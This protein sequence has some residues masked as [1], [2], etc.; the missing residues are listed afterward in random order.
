MSVELRPMAW[1]DVEA[2]HAIEQRVFAVDP[3]SA[4]Q[5]WG[6]LAQ[7]TR[8]YAVAVDGDDILGYAGL[9]RLP[10]DADVQTIAVDASAQG[11]GVGRQLLEWL[12]DQAQRADCTHLM[13]EVRSDNAAAL[14]LYERYGFERISVRRDYYGAGI[15][16]FVMRLR[17]LGGSHA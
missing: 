10:P 6:E 3:W 16:A 9:Y 14:A 7:P 13:L 4:E 1:W 12:I 8:T 5:F 2:V 17:P 11:R 15:D